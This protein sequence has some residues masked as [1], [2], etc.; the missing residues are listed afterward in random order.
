MDRWTDKPSCRVVYTRLKKA[1]WHCRAR[2][3]LRRFRTK[4]RENACKEYSRLFAS[5]HSKSRSG[6]Q[7]SNTRDNP[8][9]NNPSFSRNKKGNTIKNKKKKEAAWFFSPKPRLL[10]AIYQ[11][12]KPDRAMMRPDCVLCVC[13]I[14]CQTGVMDGQMEGQILLLPTPNSIWLNAWHPQDWKEPRNEFC[15]LFVQE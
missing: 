2:N 5:I 3:T 13:W 1:F 7:V 8:T 4:T 12:S 10:N 6:T 14:L 15:F 9:T 11:G